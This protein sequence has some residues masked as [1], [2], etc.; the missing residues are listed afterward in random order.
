[1]KKEE[2]NDF[3]KMTEKI[4]EVIVENGGAGRFG[5]WMYSYGYSVSAGLAEH[6]KNVIEGKS[7]LTDINDLSKAYG[8]FSPGAEWNGSNYNDAESGEKYENTFLIYQD[9]YILGDPGYYMGTTKVEV[10][11]KYFSIK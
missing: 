11:E 8:V 9:T 3:E 4:E 6:A 1:M 10:P 2:N 5:T 7:V